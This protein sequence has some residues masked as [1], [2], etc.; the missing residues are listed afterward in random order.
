MRYSMNAGPLTCVQGATQMYSSEVRRA[1]RSQSI[2]T[3]VFNFRRVTANRGCIVAI[4]MLH[5]RH[6]Y[7][8][9]ASL[10]SDLTEARLRRECRRI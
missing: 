2:N 10:R 9:R 3:F 5:Q 6:G 1:R 8:R 4:P 7:L